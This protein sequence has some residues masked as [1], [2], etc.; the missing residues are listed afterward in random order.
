MSISLHVVNNHMF[1]SFG[2]Y[3]ATKRVCPF[4]KA[5]EIQYPMAKIM[6]MPEPDP[7]MA[8]LRIWRIFFHVA[9]LADVPVVSSCDMLR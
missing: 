7:C 1:L 6:H 9:D 5:L 2:L 8:M 3:F 4:T